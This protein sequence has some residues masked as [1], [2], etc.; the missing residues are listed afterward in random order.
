MENILYIIGFII[1]NSYLC[2]V[3]D[4]AFTS[5]DNKKYLDTVEM[6]KKYGTFKSIKSKERF[7]RQE[8]KTRQKRNREEKLNQQN[9]INNLQI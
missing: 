7:L 5:T 9:L 3:V 6:N 1:I 8:Y 4:K 2:K